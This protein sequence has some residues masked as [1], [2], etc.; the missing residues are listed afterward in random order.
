MVV[1]ITPGILLA[2]GVA[3]LLWGVWAIAAH[4]LLKSPWDGPVAG[5]VYFWSLLYTRVYHQ[6]RIIN[7]HHIP[8]QREP[9]PLIVVANHTAGIDP[10]LIQTACPF[11]IRWVM[12]EDM[13]LPQYD[14]FWKWQRVIFINRYEPSH[15]AIREAIRH[16]R[17][18]GVLGIFPEGGLERP[19]RVLRPFL[20]GVGLLVRRTGASVLPILIEGAP[21]ADHAWA[22]L[23][24]PSRARL[25]IGEP[26]RFADR[27]SASE[28]IESLEQHYRD[29]TGWPM[30]TARSAAREVRNAQAA[31]QADQQG[32][33]RATEAARRASPKPLRSKPHA[34]PDEHAPPQRST[35][36]SQAPGLTPRSSRHPRG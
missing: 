14:A 29:W 13:R 8:G 35:G 12:A 26:I 3:L 5:A 19:P 24:T 6:M 16:I 30:Q 18:G 11:P 17:D 32:A 21:N 31:R 23:W 4:R 15:Q 28:I 20:D 10:V 34:A 1:L 9:G 7:K 25:T 27:L 36:A 33:G 22:S 2:L